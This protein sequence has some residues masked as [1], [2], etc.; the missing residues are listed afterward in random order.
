MAFC[1]KCG[2]RIEDQAAFCPQCGQARAATPSGTPSGA[3]SGTP[4]PVAGATQVGLPE[5]AAGALCYA[6]WWITGIIFLLIDNRPAVRF[7][8]AQSIVVFGGLT[9]VNLL[10][11]VIFGA[12]MFFGGVWV[13]FSAGLLLVTVVH[14][15][16]FLLWIVC[17]VMA[18]QGKRFEI[19]IAAGIAQGIVAK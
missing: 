16:E 13:G 9:V 10:L 19:P 15:L 11:G 17:M 6:L 3:P 5:N 7:H 4:G 1:S 18:A 8:A 2:A 12:G 14:L